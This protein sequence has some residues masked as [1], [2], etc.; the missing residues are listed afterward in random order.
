MC[1]RQYSKLKEMEFLIFVTKDNGDF[2]LLNEKMIKNL[3]YFEIKN[4]NFKL[5]LDTIP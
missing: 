1:F 3:F 4:N 5:I 2:N